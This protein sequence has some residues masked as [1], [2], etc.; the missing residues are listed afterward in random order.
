MVRTF[1]M[2][3]LSS[4]QIYCTE[5]LI[6][7]ITLYFK[8]PVLTYLITRS[9]GL[10]NSFIQFSNAQLLLEVTRNL[11]SFSMNYNF[12]FCLFFRFYIEVSLYRIHLCLFDLFKLGCPQDPSFVTNNRVSF[13]LWLNNIPVYTHTT[14]SLFVHPPM[15]A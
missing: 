7:V 10:L 2:Y 1:R 13:F 11:I 14:F 12:C 5:F 3:S 8:S 15:D 4:I 9:S 6:T